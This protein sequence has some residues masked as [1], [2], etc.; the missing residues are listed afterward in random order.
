VAAQEA[1]K[2]LIT[3]EQLVPELQLQEPPQVSAPLEELLASSL[4]LK[5]ITNWE[6]RL[7]I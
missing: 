5:K 4:I 3:T 6:P 7:I 2:E 1:A